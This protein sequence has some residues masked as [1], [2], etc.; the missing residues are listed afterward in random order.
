MSLILVVEA[1]PLVV[2][3]A[4][5]TWGI[6]T[7]YFDDNMLQRLGLSGLAFGATLKLMADVQ[8]ANGQAACL[9]LVYGAATYAAGTLVKQFRR[10]RKS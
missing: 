8:E 7:P 2:L 6:F 3:L 4:V 10:A 5:C 9:I 1:A